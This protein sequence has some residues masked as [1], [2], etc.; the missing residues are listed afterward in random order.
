VLDG[1]CEL[2][3]VKY[4]Y[5]CCLPIEQCILIRQ[6]AA[7]LNHGS[8][9]FRVCLVVCLRYKKLSHIFCHAC[10]KLGVCLVVCSRY[11][12]LSHILSHLYKILRHNCGIPKGICHTFISQQ[13]V[14]STQ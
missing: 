11:Q 12:K 9:R 1:V 3:R 8:S 10:L 13:R 5:H 7:K 2:R 14:G 4:L 6:T